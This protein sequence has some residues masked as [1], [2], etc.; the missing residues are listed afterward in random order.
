LDRKVTQLLLKSAGAGLGSQ[1]RKYNVKHPH[2][3]KR[4]APAK[5]TLLGPWTRSQRHH[6]DRHVQSV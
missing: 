6:R 2:R 3:I 1:Q 4:K 5:R